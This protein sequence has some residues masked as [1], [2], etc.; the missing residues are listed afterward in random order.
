MVTGTFPSLPYVYQYDT[1]EDILQ[2]RTRLRVK[3]D[4]ADIRV[5]TLLFYNRC[6]FVWAVHVS[7]LELPVSSKTVD[8]N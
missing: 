4:E 6:I 3:G 7:L 2:L 1:R 8:V 5:V